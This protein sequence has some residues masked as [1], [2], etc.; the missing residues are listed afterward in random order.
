MRTLRP[1]IAE[2]VRPAL[3]A[4]WPVRLS[5]LIARCWAA[6]PEERPEFTAICR[7]FEEMRDAVCAAHAKR[8]GNQEVSAEQAARGAEL[9]RAFRRTAR[10]KAGLCHGCAVA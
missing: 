2:G 5:T 8:R 7:E 4:H 9:L 1:A 3:P 10:L 6:A